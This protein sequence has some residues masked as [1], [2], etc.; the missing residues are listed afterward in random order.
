[1]QN[2]IHQMEIFGECTG[3]P[4]CD[5][6]HKFFEAG[7][8]ILSHITPTAHALWA[9]LQELGDAQGLLPAIQGSSR[10]IVAHP[11]V[12]TDYNFPDMFVPRPQRPARLPLRPPHPRTDRQVTNRQRCS[13]NRC[14]RVM[15]VQKI[16]RRW[17]DLHR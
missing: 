4:L 6:W 14:T 11:Y 16:H 8:K 17:I 7:A 10:I 13:R 3:Q 12:G 9:H 5:T 2:R 1:M 15:R